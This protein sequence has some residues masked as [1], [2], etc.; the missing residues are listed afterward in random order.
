MLAASGARLAGPRREDQ[1]R[2]A[3]DGV[4]PL[5]QHQ[6]SLL[7][8]DAAPEMA[9][10]VVRQDFARLASQ[11]YAR[12]RRRDGAARPLQPGDRLE[13]AMPIAG[14][15]ELE[16][17]AAEATR[18]TLRTRGDHPEAGR[19]TVAAEAEGS[20]EVRLSVLTRT[21][22]NGWRNRLAYAT[23]GELLQARLWEVFLERLAAAAGGEVLGGVQARTA[24]VVDEPADRQP[25]P[26]PVEPLHEVR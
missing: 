22:A 19:V 9:M 7:V 16:V 26:V 13:V 23:G 5:L 12:F 17:V 1:A 4:G 18:L 6:A 14:T 8:R 24:R 25:L 21:R 10:A 2:V 15:F 3:T 20:R 11:P